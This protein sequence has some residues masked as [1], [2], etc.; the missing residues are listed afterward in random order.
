MND[1][2]TE[3]LAAIRRIRAERL[4]EL[5]RDMEQRKLKANQDPNTNGS[6]QQ[7]TPSELP[8]ESSRPARPGR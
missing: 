4:E 7:D 3:H 1:P 5:M 2:L 8:Q 6:R